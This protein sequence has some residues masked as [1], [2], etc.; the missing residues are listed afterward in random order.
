MVSW[1][2]GDIWAQLLSSCSIGLLSPSPVSFHLLCFHFPSLSQA[3]SAHMALCLGF[4]P[5]A[6]FLISFLTS[7]TSS[8]EV[9]LL[10]PSSSSS[11]F[12]LFPPPSFPSCCTICIAKADLPTP[13]HLS[14]PRGESSCRSPRSPIP[15]W[16][17]ALP[18]DTA[19]ACACFVKPG[20]ATGVESLRLSV[21]R[22]WF[23]S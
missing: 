3:L 13:L 11:S 9:F 10:L 5:L 18:A 22:I 15:L 2:E 16:L 12:L 4:L 17:C 1:A 14:F 23:C 7:G 21:E 19:A 20:G 6:A 8:V